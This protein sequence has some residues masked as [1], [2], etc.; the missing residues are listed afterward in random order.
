MTDVDE[1]TLVVGLVLALGL[2]TTGFLF[3]NEAPRFS[4]ALA[5]GM[6]GEVTIDRFL[7]QAIHPTYKP[8]DFAVK[9]GRYVSDKGPLQSMLAVPLVWLLLKVNAPMIMGVYLT[10]F[11]LAAL[12]T[13][14]TALLIFRF[15]QRVHRTGTVSPALPAL[16]YALATHAFFY[17]TLFFAYALTTFL[18]FASFYLLFTAD[19]E[20]DRAWAIAAGVLVGLAGTNDYPAILLTPCLL[21][22]CRM[23]A[24]RLVPGFLVGSLAALSLLPIYHYALFGEP[25]S[26]PHRYHNMSGTHQQGV[27][28]GV[29]KFTPEAFFGVTVG[30]SRGLF[31][32][33]PVLIIAIV[34]LG[35]LHRRHPAE[36]M[37]IVAV[38]IA[39]FLFQTSF[40]DWR[41]GN[42]FGPRY[43]V[44]TLP[45]LVL[46]LLTLRRHGPI[47]PVFLALLAVSFLVNLVCA[48][49]HLPK[50]KDRYPA[51]GAFLR[52]ATGTQLFRLI[53]ETGEPY[54]DVTLRPKVHPLIY[55]ADLDDNEQLVRVPTLLSGLIGA[56]LLRRALDGGG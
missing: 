10:T 39:L 21:L 20:Q 28:M 22:Y 42:S 13:A 7:P 31:V 50:T 4:L 38:S 14:L 41:G 25:F 17:G 48:A 47:W 3:T 9:D 29:G 6:R 54:E 27:Y 18:A 26:P 23:K 37:L 53:P 51:E 35:R 24:P 52:W 49:S 46:P 44:P 56:L 34:L 19:R 5:L 11:L 33:S 16:V 15:G 12:P 8:I 40:I 30:P 36:T 45:F 1:R 43:L 32:I 55:W 2:L